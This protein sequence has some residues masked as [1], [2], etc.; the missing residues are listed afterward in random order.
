MHWLHNKGVHNA[1]I[2][3]TSRNR[4]SLVAPIRCSNRHNFIGKGAWQ[5]WRAAAWF[6]PGPEDWLAWCSCPAGLEQRQEGRLGYFP[7]ITPRLALKGNKS[8]PPR[9]DKHRCRHE[10]GPSCVTVNLVVTMFIDLVPLRSKPR[11]QK[12]WTSLFCGF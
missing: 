4:N 6:Q 8:R 10:F 12:D 7:H 11:G 2:I 9:A 5:R 1:H 3:C